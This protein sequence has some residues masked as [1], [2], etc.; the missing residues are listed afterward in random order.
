MK[1]IRVYNCFCDETRLRI[2]NLL[3]DGPLCVCHLAEIL[4]VAQPRIS[5]HLKPLVAGGALE[6]KRARNWTICRLPEART[7]LLEANLKCLQDLRGEE[8]VFN[9]DLAARKRVLKTL[10]ECGGEHLPE[11]GQNKGVTASAPDPW[12]TNRRF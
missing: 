1:A 7:A 12:T 3:L 11:I 9:E 5:R 10:R 8:S 2:L 6:T 4:G